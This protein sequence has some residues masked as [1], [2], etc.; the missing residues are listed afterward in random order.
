MRTSVL[1]VAGL[2]SSGSRW[3][4][5]PIIGAIFQTE[6]SRVPSKRGARSVRG[7]AVEA[8]GMSL[9]GARRVRFWNAVTAAFCGVLPALVLIRAYPA[10]W[11]LLLAGFLIGLVWSNGFEYAYHRW[12][13]HW[14]KGTLG[15]GH[16]L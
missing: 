15:K 16:L 11:R 12:L 13:L 14:P 7:A 10:R 3:R 5:S 9:N 1:S 8:F 6:S 4:K 2:V